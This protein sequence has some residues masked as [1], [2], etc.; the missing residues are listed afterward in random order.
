MAQWK[1][2][3]LGTMM[4]RV[5]SLA[6]LSELRIQC[7]CGSGVGWWLQLRLDPLAWE[8]PHATCLALKKRTKRQNNNNNDNKELSGTS[9][10]IKSLREFPL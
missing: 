2:I 1:R 5:R 8:P 3:R 10:S 4:L 7:C 9:K 6:L